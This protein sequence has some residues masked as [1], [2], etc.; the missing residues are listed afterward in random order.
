MGGQI[1]SVISVQSVVRDFSLCHLCFFAAPVFFASPYTEEPDLL[2]G[3]SDSSG[4][5]EYL[6]TGV[7]DLRGVMKTLR[8]R[9]C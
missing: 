3:H 8:N 4:S 6:R 5:S 9:M 1:L 2:L 7:W